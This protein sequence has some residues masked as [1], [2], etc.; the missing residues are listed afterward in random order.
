MNI[1]ITQKPLRGTVKAPVSKSDAH[2]KL[3]CAALSDRPTTMSLPE[4]CADID[5]TIRC[6]T[7]LG[8]K[9]EDKNGAVTVTPISEIPSHAT[10]DCGESGSTLRFMLPVAAALGCSARFVGAGRLPE[11]PIGVLTEQMEQ[12]GVTFSA[13]K[14]PF[15]MTG[16]MTGGTFTLPGNVSSQFITGLLLA[17]PVIGGGKIELTSAL[18]SAAY[19]EMTRSAMADFGVT[20]RG[21]TVENEKYTSPSCAEIDGDWSSAA[22]LLVA[23]A[24]GGEVSVTGL[25][26]N[27]I[28][29]DK[30]VVDVLKR[31]GADVEIEK[32]RVTVRKSALHGVEI[33]VRE[34]PDLLPVLSI[35]AAF[36][37]GETD[38]VNAERLRIKES[39]RIESTSQMLTALGI[40]NETGA[41]FLKVFGGEPKCG[42]VDGFGDHRIVMSAAVAGS[43]CSCTVTDAQATEKSYPAFWKDFEALGGMI[44]KI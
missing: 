7:S 3:I 10:L 17:L 35:A 15:E 24:V 42:K 5:A 29:G 30:T 37:Q 39:D 20:V 36:A 6:L 34:I 18:E 4:K 31:M 41:D 1:S 2:R 19:V 14:L 12:H 8:A 23:G 13:P 25:N 40:K 32:N 28:Q 38:F 16:K 11:R 22:F 27:S 9:I 43:V 44:E 26:M 21:L 33:D